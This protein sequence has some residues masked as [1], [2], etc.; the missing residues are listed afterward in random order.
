MHDAL[1]PGRTLPPP[2]PRA[3]H[4]SHRSSPPPGSARVRRPRRSARARCRPR[5]QLGCPERPVSVARAR[6]PYRRATVRAWPAGPHRT[7]GAA[8][9]GRSA[10]SSFSRS[11]ACVLR[12]TSTLVG[13]LVFHRARCEKTLVPVASDSAAGF[14]SADSASSARRCCAVFAALCSLRCVRC[15]ARLLNRPDR[16]A[17]ASAARTSSAVTARLADPAPSLSLSSAL[18]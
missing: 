5:S 15:A 3:G 16:T 9:A 7:R 4:P 14:F 8:A 13:R 17:R 1:V 11:R 2:L 10:V 6:R 12:L 18:C